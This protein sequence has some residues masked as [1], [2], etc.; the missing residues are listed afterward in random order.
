[1]PAVEAVSNEETIENGNFIGLHRL[2]ERRRGD[3]SGGIGYGD[4]TG[5]WGGALEGQGDERKTKA[6]LL[7]ESGAILGWFVPMV[8]KLCYR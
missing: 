8:L 4:T 6:L 2:P 7:E 5:Q 1:M 3:P